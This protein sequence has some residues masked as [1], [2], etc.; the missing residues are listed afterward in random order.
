MAWLIYVTCVD[1]KIL[2]ATAIGSSL[3]RV[4]TF[5]AKQD[6]QSTGGRNIF[7]QTLKMEG[8]DKNK[9]NKNQK[10]LI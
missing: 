2:I 9:N 8:E 3:T 10:M 1:T 4:L 6:R 5:S 7:L